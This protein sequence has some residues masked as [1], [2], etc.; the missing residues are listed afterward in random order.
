[1]S[2]YAKLNPLYKALKEFG[3][4]IKS[5]FLLQYLDNLELRQ[6]IEKQLNKVELSHKFAKAV[7]YG[8]SQEFQYEG[9]GMQ[10][11]V[12][13]C[14]RLIQ[15]SIILWN[16][17]YLTQLLMVTKDINKKQQMLKIIQMGSIIAWQHINLHGTYDFTP[18]SSKN[19]QT[20]DLKSI[21]MFKLDR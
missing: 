12:A 18:T 10:N 17:L 2:S 11:I 15:N 7:Y 14:K 3:R 9:K 19:S 6:S 13:G 21:L 20:F 8:N 1:M 4:I 5:I 16:Y